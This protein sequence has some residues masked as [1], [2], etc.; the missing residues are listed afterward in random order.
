MNNSISVKI[1]GLD[2]RLSVSH[3]DQPDLLQAAEL[4]E[5][6]MRS[7]QE[8]GKVVGLNRIAVL[9]ALRLAHELLRSRK[10]TKKNEG[11]KKESVGISEE[12]SDIQLKTLIDNVNE[13]LELLQGAALETKKCS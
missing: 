6:Y 2:Y 5:S 10:E 13:A 7:I 3:E 12:D 8:T 11:T 1:L 4:V 9:T